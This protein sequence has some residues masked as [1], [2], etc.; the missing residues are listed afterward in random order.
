MSLH[1]EVFL[2]VAVIV[3][4]YYFVRMPHIAI[5]GFDALSWL[6]TVCEIVQKNFDVI[7]LTGGVG[8][9]DPHQI[10]RILM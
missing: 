8:S 4:T 3:G 10:S 7:P 2:R 1:H 6:E 5:V 9:A